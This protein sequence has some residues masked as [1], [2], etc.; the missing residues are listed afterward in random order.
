MDRQTSFECVSWLLKKEF[1]TVQAR[2]LRYW[3]LFPKYLQH[4]LR[5]VE[6]YQTWVSTPDALRP[7]FEFCDVLMEF[8]W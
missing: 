6:N 5:L 4:L 2:R 7:T 1:S 8:C 3:P